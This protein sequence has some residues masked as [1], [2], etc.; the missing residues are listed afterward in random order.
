MAY[1]VPLYI[2]RGGTPMAKYHMG[3]VLKHERENAG[4][5]QE[6]LAGE[7]VDVSMISRYERGVSTPSLKTLEALFERMGA[8]ASTIPMYLLSPEAIRIQK[9]TDK[10]NSYLASRDDEEAGK[11]IEKLEAD[12]KFMEVGI[13]RQYLNLMKAQ[14]AINKNESGSEILETL[15]Q[16]IQ[17][18]HKNLAIEKIGDSFLSTTDTRILSLMAIQYFD[19]GDP[20]KAADILYGLK[21]N[22]ETR[23][24][25]KN[26][27]GR[28]Y[29]HVIIT[30]T[31]V[32]LGFGEYEKIIRLCAEGRRVCIE[33]GHLWFLPTLALRE[34]EA[35]VGIEDYDTAKMCIK[36]AY[37]G[38]WLQ[39][40]HHEKNY[41]KNYA[42][43]KLGVEL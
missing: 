13:H 36:N 28:R 3:H 14:L 12:E 33:T 39:E 5:T 8:D 26:E 38:Y 37:H 1:A 25:D 18:S 35:C 43:E 9:I 29:P 6:E 17:I 34:A 11:K 41:A 10:L 23:A 4:M 40:R 19:L 20:K 2:E 30:L 42:K 7:I 16:A 22:L 24:I 15:Q 31:N 21:T 27:R 32:L